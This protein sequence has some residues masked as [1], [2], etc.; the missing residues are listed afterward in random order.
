MRGRA[1]RHTARID[2]E[3][4][5]VKL[6][7]WLYGRHLATLTEPG[8]LQHR[9]EFT[10]EAL[11]VFGQRKALLSLSLPTTSKPV[12]TRHV[13]NFLDGLL[14]EGQIRTEIA[15]RTGVAEYDVMGLLAHV[16]RE[17]A[18][19]IQVMEP[20]AQPEGGRLE[21]LSA[22]DMA[23]MVADLP[24]RDWSEALAQ[25]ASL[26]GV[27]DKLLIAK[28]G[29][30]W[31]WPLDGA[32]STHIVKPQPFGTSLDTLILSEHWAMQL[33]ASSGVDVAETELMMFDDREAIVVTR[34][35]RRDGQRIHQED[36]CQA[37]GLAPNDK[38][39][40]DLRGPSRFSQIAHVARRGL[41][42]RHGFHQ[43]LLRAATF[44]VLIG[45]GDSHSKNYSLLISANGDVGL[46]PLYDVAPTF[47]LN[48]S[49]RNSGQLI[50]SRVRLDEITG[51]DLVAEAK[52]WGM[53][54][55]DAGRV[56]RETIEATMSALDDAEIPDRMA[57]MISSLR[58]LLG[59]R[60]V[61]GILVPE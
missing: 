16:G 8:R 31:A 9:L 12:E 5:G 29:E 34:F 44:N 20:G 6:H 4:A 51:T 47:H 52:S 56:V 23:A 43:A 61:T 42:D 53:D 24:T 60:A 57:P 15:R 19:A 40:T 25:H 49:Y 46:A 54:E 45:N 13:R 18:G 33:A 28:T 39:E 17:C 36:F 10:Q 58:R 14:P 37:L 11:D 32:M 50:G 55:Q 3:R 38:Y 59:A 26:A 2:S 30:G 48:A 1:G 27:Q 21:P 7:V 35:D 41:G 22:T